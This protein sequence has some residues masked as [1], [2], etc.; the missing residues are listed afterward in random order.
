MTD[1]FSVAHPSTVV[2]AGEALDALLSSCWP[3]I[4]ETEHAGQI[5]RIITVCWLNLCDQEDETDQAATTSDRNHI[6]KQLFMSSR[7]FKS[8]WA[9][10]DLEMQHKLAEALSREP[11]LAPLFPEYAS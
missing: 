7:I 4:I 10:P 6:R 3:R 1:P 5:L 9:R 8:V 2:A 11:R